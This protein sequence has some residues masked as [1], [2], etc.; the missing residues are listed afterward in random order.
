MRWDEKE[1]WRLSAY[2]GEDAFL[3][4]ELLCEDGWLT[5]AELA[6]EEDVRVLLHKA[7]RR[8]FFEAAGQDDPAEEAVHWLKESDTHRVWNDLVDED[9]HLR[10]PPRA[11][12]V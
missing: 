6:E 1:L 7:A 5:A 2:E 11:L 4:P 12:A 8:G 10:A 3:D 9:T